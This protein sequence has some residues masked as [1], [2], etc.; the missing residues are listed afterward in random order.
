MY[1]YHKSSRK[2]WLVPIFLEDRL[3]FFLEGAAAFLLV[4]PAAL[5]YDLLWLLV[6]SLILLTLVLHAALLRY[7]MRLTIQPAVA[8][9]KPQMVVVRYGAPILGLES[10]A[11]LLRTRADE[12]AAHPFSKSIFYLKEHDDDAGSVAVCLNKLLP[13]GCQQSELANRYMNRWAA[14][15]GKQFHELEVEERPM[16]EL[17]RGM[18][19]LVQ[20]RQGGPVD[21]D[22]PNAKWHSLHAL[23]TRVMPGSR[24]VFPAPEV[25]A[26]VADEGPD[27]P[28]Y[29]QPGVAPEP[30]PQEALVEAAKRGWDSPVV[31]CGGVASWA[32]GQLAGEVRSGWWGWVE[33]RWQSREMFVRACARRVALRKRV[34]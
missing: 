12:D 23:G 19:S 22:G 2:R 7:N 31:V 29:L 28:I 33:P 14:F 13:Q 24:R 34:F 26:E 3:A 5:A 16:G 17:E 6:G 25:Q 20:L 10:G 9:E 32:P 4:F 18:R 1:A 8:G 27:R 11:L 15:D 21:K 30:L